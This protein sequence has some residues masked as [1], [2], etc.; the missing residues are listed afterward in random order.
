MSSYVGLAVTVNGDAPPAFSIFTLA[1]LFVV[2]SALYYPFDKL[3]SSLKFFSNREW[4]V[5]VLGLFLSVPIGGVTVF[6]G[7]FLLLYFGMNAWP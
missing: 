3:C 2:L 1:I 7:L 5:P 4:I 6:I